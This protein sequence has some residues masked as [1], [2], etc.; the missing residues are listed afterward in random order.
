MLVGGTD[1]VS[2]HGCQSNQNFIQVTQ[3]IFGIT[4]INARSLVNKLPELHFLLYD[5]TYGSHDCICVTESWLHADLLDGLLDPLSN[6]DIFRNDRQY[7][8]GGGVCVFVRRE[9]KALQIYVSGAPA[10]ADIVCV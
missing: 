5:K 4:L 8:R 3:S 10:V 9:F 2:A 6:Y 7:S 1:S